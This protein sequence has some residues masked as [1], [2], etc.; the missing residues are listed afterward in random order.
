MLKEIEATE[1]TIYPAIHHRWTNASKVMWQ[2]TSISRCKP[3]RA[4]EGTRSQ[5]DLLSQAP[6]VAHSV[7]QGQCRD[8][9]QSIVEQKCQNR[10]DGFSGIVS[11]VLAGSKDFHISL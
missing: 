5:L 7:A 6:G 2:V 9:M 11:A 3:R 8:T 4:R 10:A 1:K